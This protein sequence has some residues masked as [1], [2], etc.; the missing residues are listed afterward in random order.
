MQPLLS[1]IAFVLRTALCAFQMEINTW[2]Y[3]GVGQVSLSHFPMPLHSLSLSCPFSSSI[4]LSLPHSI[5]LSL[6]ASL[7]PSFSH[8]HPPLFSSPCPPVSRSLSLPPSL[9]LC[10]SLCLWLSIFL[11]FFH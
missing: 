1:L 7:S 3:S 11:S 10:P 9:F 2:S 6:S 4:S 5:L 8:L